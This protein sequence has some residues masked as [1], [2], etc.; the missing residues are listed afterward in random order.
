M[1]SATDMQN[2]ANSAHANPKCVVAGGP[3]CS[4]NFPA[5]TLTAEEKEAMSRLI[6]LLCLCA[7]FMLC[8]GCDSDPVTGSEGGSGTGNNGAASPDNSE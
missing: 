7:G 5:T 6:A 3:A 2:A 8:A 1:N 4:F